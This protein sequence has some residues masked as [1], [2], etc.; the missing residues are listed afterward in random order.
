MHGFSANSAL[1]SASLSGWYIF[2]RVLGPVGPPGP[3]LLPF[4]YAV[5]C[6]ACIAWHRQRPNGDAQ[7]WEKEN[8]EGEPGEGKT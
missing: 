2:E 7:K 3:S 4:T 6:S 5:D 8:K 1:N